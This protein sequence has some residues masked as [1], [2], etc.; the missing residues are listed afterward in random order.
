MPKS[1]IKKLLKAVANRELSAVGIFIE[2]DNQLLAEV[3]FEIDWDE[4]QR[5]LNKLHMH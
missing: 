4:H 1:K 5:M 3:E 2:E